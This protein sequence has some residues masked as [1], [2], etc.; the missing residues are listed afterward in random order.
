MSEGQIDEMEEIKRDFI[1]EAEELLDGLDQSLIE[2]EKEPRSEDI[3]NSIFRS[4]HTIK[5]AAGFLAFDSI[6]S[7]AHAAEDV[8]NKLRKGSLV[9]NPSIMDALLKAVDMLRLLITHIKDDDGVDE[10]ISEVTGLLRAIKSGDGEISAKDEGKE[11]VSAVEGEIEEGIETRIDDKD[12]KVSEIEL[13]ASD[14]EGSKKDEAGAEDVKGDDGEKE[15]EKGVAEKSGVSNAVDKPRDVKKDDTDTIRVDTKRL[16]NVLNMVGELVLSRNRLMR[17]GSQLEDRYAED[18]LVSDLMQTLYS[19]NVITT[20]LQLAV[21]KTRMQPI[22]K[23]FQKF[24]RMVRDIAREKGKDVELI[25][26]GKD[27][28]V[29]KT[30]IEEIGNPLIHLVR[31]A[32][33]HG[34]ETAEERIKA[35]KPSKGRVILSAYHKGDNMFVKIEDDGGGM[36]LKRIREKAVEKG[37]VSEDEVGRMSDKEMVGFIFHPGFSTARKVTDIS[38]RGVGM[39]VVKTHITRLNGSVDIETEQGRGTRITLR[40]PLTLAIIQALMVGAGN[41]YYALPLSTVIEILKVR[42]SEVKKVDGRSVVYTRGEVY[43]LV[44]LTEVL[45]R[46]TG[47]GRGGYS[48]I[49]ALGEKKVAVMVEKLL[50]QE[51]VVIKSVGEYLSDREMKGLSGATITGDGRVVLIVDVSE[52]FRG[53]GKEMAL[54]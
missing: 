3:L 32:V 8:L 27:T 25:M 47:N 45:G 44:Y 36:D 52:L 48:V 4:F 26:N 35:G 12:K 20:D 41:E 15:E 24:P 11:D 22:S 2:L 53:I 54:C 13:E 34:V 30:V 23:V 14:K 42:P 40:L 5:G 28:E 43:P 1:L 51:E 19:L 50:G 46:G 9:V 37:L 7:V 39:D 38:G 21:M 31:N 16:D 29:D 49:V 6:V 33:D 17:L 18:E 10:D